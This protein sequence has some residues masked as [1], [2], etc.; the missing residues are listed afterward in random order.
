MIRTVRPRHLGATL[1]LFAGLLA[2][3]HARHEAAEPKA[4]V[5]HAV[6]VRNG[7]NC[8]VC[9]GDMSAGDAD[10]LHLP[11][12]PI[13]VD[14]HK[15]SHAGEADKADCLSCHQEEEAPTALRHLKKS[16]TFDHKRHLKETGGQCVTCHKNAATKD[17]ARTGAIPTMSDCAQCHQPWL[18]E[19]RCEACHNNL[20]RYPLQPVTHQA[21]IG[22]FLRR[23]G[24]EART[25]VDRCS[26]C[27]TQTFCADC[28]DKRAPVA[29]HLQW[30]D[31]IDRNFIHEPN[32]VQRHAP[33]ARIE[34]PLCISCHSES[35]CLGCHTA[36]GRGPGGLNPHPRG[37][38]SLTPGNGNRHGVEA[39]RDILSCA[40]CHSGP[41]ADLCID[42]HAVGR[43][44][45]SPHPSGYSAGGRLRQ[46]QPCV[47]CHAG[48][49]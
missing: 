4:G 1:A 41:G 7:V 42:C 47:R 5:G 40:S 2:G 27:H 17:S 28:H 3:C 20:V 6:H 37:W 31:R 25:A 9:H 13:C 34:G 49:R 45:G 32:F 26:Q 43:P 19:L 48:G 44:G 29:L 18:D 38:A 15:D 39:R 12:N 24:A 16:L 33:E 36:A 23:H 21:H 30:A 11:T 8:T 46:D 35:E 14:C 10:A 22:D